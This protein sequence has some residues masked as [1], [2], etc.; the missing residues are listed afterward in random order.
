MPK[1][2]PRVDAYI[3]KSADF[4]RPILNRIRKLVHAACPDAV[5][6]IKWN[7]P[8]F[9]HKGILLT[10]PAFKQHCALI[11]WKGRL[12]L[13]KD[14]EKLRRITSTADLP[15]TIIQT[16]SKIPRGRNQRRRK[17]SCRII[18]WLHSRRTKRRWPPSRILAPVANGNTSNGS[19]EPSAKKRESNG[20][21]LQSSG[22]PP[23]N[24]GTGNTTRRNSRHRWPLRQQSPHP[25]RG[26]T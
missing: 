2:D 22:L 24:R 12:F 10:V 3:A 9:E 21:R 17:L 18:F 16:P 7:A 1:P 5:E 26:P 8:F 11:F 20:F 13:G 4:A 19:P 23:G 6:T 14:R 25:A 15:A